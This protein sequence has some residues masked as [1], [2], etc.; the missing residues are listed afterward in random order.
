MLFQENDPT[1]K[2]DSYYSL[3][4]TSNNLTEKLADVESSYKQ[5]YPNDPFD[6]YFIDDYFN[7]QYEA[8]VRFGKLFSV[9]SMLT[10]FIALLGLVGLG[11][12]TVNIRMKEIGIRKVLGASVGSIVAILTKNT[13]VL[14]GLSCL[15][16][17]PLAY[18]AA[19][20]WLSSY[21]FRIELNVFF[22]L[23]VLIVPVVVLTTVGILSYKAA[24][25]NPTNT[26]RDE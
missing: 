9:F 1:Y 22:L 20:N 17:L 19:D 2:L 10:V 16:S 18:W 15:L 25:V 3:R 24:N 4:L 21:A 8:D 13:V 12:H 14:V 23:P 6:Y 11:L 7:A 26:L 5:A